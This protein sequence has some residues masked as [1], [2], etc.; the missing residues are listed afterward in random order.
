MSL[1]ITTHP[2]HTR[3]T[4]IFNACFP[5][6][7]CHRTL[8]RALPVRTDESR[9]RGGDGPAGRPRGLGPGKDHHACQADGAAANAQGPDLSGPS[10][11]NGLSVHRSKSSL[12]GGFVWARRARDSQKRRFPAPPGSHALDPDEAP[13]G[14]SDRAAYHL[15][16]V[17]FSA[18][19]RVL[20]KTGRHASGAV[21]R[22]YQACLHGSLAARDAETEGV[23]AEDVSSALAAD[24]GRVITDN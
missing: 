9:R 15:A 2:L 5:K 7:Q 19:Y 14:W 17:A 22:T 21:R 6:R 18:E 3:F 20:L 11:L 16:P 8:G 1:C 10:R 4:N 24:G 23:E 12:Y 13:A